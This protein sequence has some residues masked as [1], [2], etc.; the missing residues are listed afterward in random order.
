MF[1]KCRSDVDA[2]ITAAL[3]GPF[4]IYEFGNGHTLSECTA[5]GYFNR[6]RPSVDFILVS[7]DPFY[8]EKSIHANGI[9]L[10]PVLNFDR[11]PFADVQSVV[12]L[13]RSHPQRL[14]E[15][16]DSLAKFSANNIYVCR[17]SW[18]SRTYRQDY[19]LE[20]TL[21]KTGVVDGE[22]LSSTELLTHIIDCLVE[23]KRR[24]IPGDILNLGVYKGWSM[25]FIAEVCAQIDLRDRTLFG[26][27]TF[28]GFEDT[29]AELSDTFVPYMKSRFGENVA[30]HT[31]T[32]VPF[33]AERLSAYPNIQLVPGDIAQTIKEINGK[34]VCLALFDMDNYTPTKVALRPVY[35]ALSTGGFIIHDHFSL[36]SC[37]H[38]GL[39]G[40]RKAMTEFLNETAMFNLTGTNVF[41]R[42]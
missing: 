26:F 7:D 11:L 16:V 28:N 10:G 30:I 22:G 5:R 40:Q 33:V 32:S 15:R 38:P 20:K 23:I 31:N 27:D 39:Y 2:I 3:H 36:P 34:S 18:E 25:H 6:L 17:E 4:A 24:N 12:I 42:S 8:Q 41:V 21:E 35:S 13:D 14:F 29:S 19:F 37:E 1:E 9:A